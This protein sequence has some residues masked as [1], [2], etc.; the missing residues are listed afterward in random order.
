VRLCLDV[1]SRSKRA[2]FGSSSTCANPLGE[3]LIHQGQA[4][5]I[6][7]RVHEI[8]ELIELT[9]NL[10]CSGDVLKSRARVT[11]FHAPNRVDG[12]ADTLGQSFLGQISAAAR[13]GDIVPDPAQGSLNRERNWTVLHI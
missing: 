1:S 5:R 2:G 12:G 3:V 9:E 8:F 13:Q 6:L 4:D 10:K 7:G 11:V